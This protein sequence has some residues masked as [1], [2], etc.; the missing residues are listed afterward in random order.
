MGTDQVLGVRPEAP[1]RVA[2][3]TAAAAR[4]PLRKLAQRPYMR[5]RP[6]CVLLHVRKP[7]LGLP[8]QVKCYFG[9]SNDMWP[10]SLK[11]VKADVRPGTGASAPTPLPRC[12]IAQR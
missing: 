12:C 6:L 11:C 9:S 8:T 1:Q 2:A 10:G 7:L 5:V 3:S 4:V